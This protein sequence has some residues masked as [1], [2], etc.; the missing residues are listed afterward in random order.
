[1]ELLIDDKIK[2]ADKIFKEFKKIKGFDNVW[3]KWVAYFSVNDLEKALKIA[4]ILMNSNK[5]S[6]QPKAICK[7]IFEVINRFK[8]ELNCFD[9]N[10][11]LEI[12]GYISWKLVILG[13]ELEPAARQ[14]SKPV[15]RDFKQHS[16]KLRDKNFRSK[17]QRNI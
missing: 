16:Y 2:C 4:Q 6:D 3:K 1:M 5:L 12:F 9:K 15:S 13:K 17:F 7:S 8:Q 14:P 11:I 10:T